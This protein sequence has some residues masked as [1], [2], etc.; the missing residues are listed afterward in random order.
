MAVAAARIWN[1]LEDFFFAPR[2]IHALV[3]ARIIFGASLFLCYVNRLPDLLA[4]YGPEGLLGP[5]LASHADTQDLYGSAPLFEAWTE[6]IRGLVAPPSAAGVQLLT[7]LLLASS[8]GFA[9]GFF[10]RT[11][12]VIALALHHFFVVSLAPYSYWGW[13][14]HIQ[15]LMAYVILAPT[16]RFLSLDEWWA[17]R[18][19]GGE[20]IPLHEWIAPAWP[21][22]LVQLHTCTMYA[23]TS[24][25]RI[26]DS[27]WIAGEAVFDSVTVALHAKFAMNWQL[28]KPLLS[29]GTYAALVLESLA[30]VCLWLSRVGPVW[31]YLLI[32][33]HATLELTTNLGWWSQIMIASL[34]SFVP[35]AQLEALLGRVSALRLRG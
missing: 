7:G 4:L 33:M 19:H 23:V 32:G 12:G 31:A 27:G 24:W 20:A 28:L 26:D 17:R 15:A 35:P 8:L 13:A 5:E 25:G 2:A 29:A 22:R 18:R 30:P 11:S 16:G 34:L 10:T 21:L 1:A 6:L 14:V 9:L 3:L